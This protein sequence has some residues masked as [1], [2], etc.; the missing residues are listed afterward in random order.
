MAKMV[1]RQVD[2]PD[3]VTVYERRATRKATVPNPYCRD[4]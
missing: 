3:M 1:E 2:Q 4:A